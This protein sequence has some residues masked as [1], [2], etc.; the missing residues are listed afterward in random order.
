MLTSDEL[1]SIMPG[2][3]AAKSA[4]FLPPLDAAMTEFAI[5]APARA[6]AFLAQLAHESGQLRFMEEIWGP[7]AQQLRYEPASSLATSLGNTQTGDGKRFKGRGPIQITGRA[8]YQR[9]GNLLGV[10]LVTT[11]EQAA[12][13]DLAFRIAGLYWSKKGLNELADQATD[14]A[15]REITRRING[16]F[17]G[18]AAR[19]QFYATAR[20]ALGVATPPVTKDMERS[21][22]PKAPEPM[23]ERGFEAIR[24]A[25]KPRRRKAAPKRRVRKATKK[26]P[27]RKV[28]SGRRTRKAAPA[29]RTKRKK[30]KR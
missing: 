1:H 20:A 16:A 6:A 30:A 25:R 21:P 14:E 3:P 8:N 23:F 27:S 26:A 11:P 2:L 28:T 9:F 12:L 7:T 18:L 22:A 17:N 29:R 10:D 4:A 13:P 24:A 19:Q 5:D 15:F